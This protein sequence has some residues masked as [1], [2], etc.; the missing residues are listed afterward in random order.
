MDLGGQ[1]ALRTTRN[2]RKPGDVGKSKFCT[3]IKNFNDLISW[4]FEIPAFAYCQ[5]LNIIEKTKNEKY[6]LYRIVNS[7]YDML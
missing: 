1:K 7:F 3:F 4:S 2:I 6:S 5:Q